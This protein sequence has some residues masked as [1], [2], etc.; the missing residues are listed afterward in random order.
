MG[1]GGGGVVWWFPF[2]WGGLVEVVLEGWDDVHVY[3]WRVCSS[4]VRR[5]GSLRSMGVSMIMVQ[6]F[7]WW[8]ADGS[9]VQVS[10][11]GW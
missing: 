4:W 7:G 6:G 11:C 9:L 5:S 1:G 2:V 3:W 10:L 8:W